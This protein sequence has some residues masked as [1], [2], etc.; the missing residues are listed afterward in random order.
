MCVS[1]RAATRMQ[2]LSRPAAV[3]WRAAMR[4]LPGLIPFGLTCG[5]FVE[6]RQPLGGRQRAPRIL[7]HDADAVAIHQPVDLVARP[8]A[9]AVGHRFWHGD[10]QFARDLGHILTIARTTALP[11]AALRSAGS[12]Q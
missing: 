8:Y 1:T 11:V 3:A 4:A 10:L 2:L 12:G 9:E 6:Q 7:R 5:G